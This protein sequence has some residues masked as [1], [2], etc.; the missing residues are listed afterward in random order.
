MGFSELDC[1]DGVVT[2]TDSCVGVGKVHE[3]AE[4]RLMAMIPCDLKVW[5]QSVYEIERPNI[6]GFDAVVEKID[7]CEIENIGGRG[8]KQSTTIMLPRLLY[9]REAILTREGRFRNKIQ[10]T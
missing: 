10:P 1:V 3:R 7:R 4:E 6:A 9:L 2:L 8:Q 5:I